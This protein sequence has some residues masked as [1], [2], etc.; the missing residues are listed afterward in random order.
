MPYSLR[1]ERVNKEAEEQKS[2]KGIWPQHLWAGM[3]AGDA[4]APVRWDFCPTEVL[5]YSLF[6]SYN[7]LWAGV[8]H[9]EADERE[10]HPL[11]W[12]AGMRVCGQVREPAYSKIAYSADGEEEE[13]LRLPCRPAKRMVERAE[14]R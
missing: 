13:I 9:R 2:R 5:E 1:S 10:Y 12:S 7:A 11:S 4:D 3:S 14:F 8:A 6:S